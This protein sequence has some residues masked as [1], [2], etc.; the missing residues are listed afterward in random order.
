MEKALLC[1]VVL[2]L[3]L[4]EILSGATNEGYYGFVP[5]T[6]SM[7]DYGASCSVSYTNKE[8]VY[9]PSMWFVDGVPILYNDPNW[10]VEEVSFPPFSSTLRSRIKNV[11]AAKNAIHVNF[12]SKSCKTTI[13]FG[14]NRDDSRISYKVSSKADFLYLNSY[15]RNG[16]MG[17]KM[18]A[19]ITIKKDSRNLILQKKLQWEIIVSSGRSIQSYKQTLP[20]KDGKPIRWKYFGPTVLSTFGRLIFSVTTKAQ[21]TRPSVTITYIRDVKL[22][23]SN[24]YSYK[25]IPSSYISDEIFCK[26]INDNTRLCQCYIL[27]DDDN[28]PNNSFMYLMSNSSNTRTDLRYSPYGYASYGYQTELYSIL[29]DPTLKEGETYCMKNAGGPPGYQIAIKTD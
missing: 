3:L 29:R 5:D 23:T 26:N 10:F 7:E 8:K 13:D 1:T 6:I 12:Y 19:D 15:P 17:F 24:A 20:I 22:A 11:D 27:E 21:W 28:S 9:V 25:T 16:A 4:K 2:L 14:E 18:P